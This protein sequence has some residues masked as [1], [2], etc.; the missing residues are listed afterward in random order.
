M[1][2]AL[3]SNKE[4]LERVFSETAKGNGQPFLE[5]L[6]EE[7][8]WR[9]IGTTGWSQTFRGKTSIL[10]DLIGPLRR[11][12]AQPMKT[13]AHRFIAEG[14]F[15]CVE[16]RGENTTRAGQPYHNTYCFVFEFRDGQI[17]AL[18]EYADTELVTQVLGPPVVSKAAAP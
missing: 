1:S 18:T 3:R 17:I 7:A 13:H 5:A 9:L 2:S 8:Q 16:A 11:V 12:L 15:V 14:N 10:R 6:A 4:C